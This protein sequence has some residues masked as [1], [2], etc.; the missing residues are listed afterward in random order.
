MRLQYISKI[1]PPVSVRT[2]VLAIFKQIVSS[3][4]ITNTYF[5]WDSKKY[6]PKEIIEQQ[7]VMMSNAKKS[8][9]K[10]ALCRFIN[11]VSFFFVLFFFCLEEVHFFGLNSLPTTHY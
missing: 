1:L 6:A 10:S 9:N 3:Q 11:D 4:I 2:F 8:K 5:L 7:Q